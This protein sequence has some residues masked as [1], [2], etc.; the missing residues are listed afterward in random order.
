MAA[1]KSAQTHFSAMGSPLSTCSAVSSSSCTSEQM[2][3]DPEINAT[4]TASLQ[5]DLLIHARTRG[6]VSA[7]QHGERAEHC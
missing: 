6:A 1:R 5:A 2:L 3:D 7:Q 4:Y